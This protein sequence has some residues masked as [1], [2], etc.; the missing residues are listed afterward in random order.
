MFLDKITHKIDYNLNLKDSIQKFW[1][2]E[3]AGVDEHPVYENFKQTI[4]FD[5]ERYV[6][7]LAFKPFHKPLP[8]N[9][10]LSKHRLSILKTKLDKNEELKQEYNQVFDNYLKDRIIEKVA[11]DDYG[12]VEKTQYL[13][14]GAVVRCDK[15][16][17]KVRLVFDASTK[18]GNEPS[19]NDCLYTGL[20]LLRQLYDI[21]VRFRLHNIILMMEL[22]AMK[23]VI[24]Y[25]FYGMR[26]HFQQNQTLSFYVFSALRL[27]LL[28]HRFC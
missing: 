6:T 14:H 26:T 13:P 21:L 15:E 8:D 7:A 3:N 2:I 12:V 11:D 28:A 25:V 27:V 10:T 18:N 20:C 5:G 23:T 16:T 22:F 1:E 19:L 9:Y 17:T 4:C 24:I